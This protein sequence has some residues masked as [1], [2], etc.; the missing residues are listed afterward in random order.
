MK[1][2]KSINVSKVEHY[3]FPGLA[4]FSCRQDLE[5]GQIKTEFRK[6]A[7]LLVRSNG[8]RHL[9]LFQGQQLPEDHARRSS[10]LKMQLWNSW[11]TLELNLNYLFQFDSIFKCIESPERTWVRSDEILKKSSS[12]STPFHWYMATG[13][14]NF[15]VLNA[16]KMKM[17]SLNYPPPSYDL[18]D[19]W[20]WK[21]DY[22]RAEWASE[23][24]Q[25]L[26]FFH[27]TAVPKLFCLN[28][29][30]FANLGVFVPK[31]WGGRDDSKLLLLIR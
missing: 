30:M 21:W 27:H 31:K 7:F 9:I 18:V 19:V 29:E 4:S 8:S 24:W 23:S 22:M 15:D 6:K 17:P 1:Q 12:F 28:A 25:W 13:G 10:K 16:T 5:F 11:W 26:P 2:L 14:T 3:E 20:R